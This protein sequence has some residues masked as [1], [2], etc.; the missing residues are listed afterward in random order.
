M[1]HDKPCR[2]RSIRNQSPFLSRQVDTELIPEP[3]RHHIVFPHRHGLL[4][5]LVFR[6]VAEHVIESPTKVSIAGSSNGRHQL[7]RCRMSVAS[8]FQSAINKPMVTRVSRFGSNDAFLKKSQRLRGLECGAGRILPH[9]GTVQ[10][11]F[12]RITAQ[13]QWFFH[14]AGPP[15]YG[16]RK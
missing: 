5:I 2:K 9:D 7:G 6:P 16:D 14:A 12:Q 10:Q 15:S 11:G 13:S 4:H 8:H 1:N 3:H